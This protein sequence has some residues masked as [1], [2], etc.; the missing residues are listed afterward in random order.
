M[1][2]IILYHANH[3]K[4]PQKWID[5]CLM[6]IRGQVIEEFDV[7]E[8][9]Y[10]PTPTQLYEGSKF[11]T[12]A[13]KEKDKTH[14][15]HS[16]AHNWLCYKAVELGYDYV[17]NTNID[18]FY[19]Y[20][21]LYRQIPFLLQGYDVVSSNMTQIDQ[22]NRV[23]MK[24][25]RIMS[26]IAFSEMSIVEH[27]SKG[28]NIIAHPACAYSANFIRKSGM[29]KPEEVPKDDFELWKRSIDKFTFKIAPYTLLYYRIWGGN[30][31]AKK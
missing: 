26:D 23:I 24:G 22:D 4:Y 19:H 3:T 7:L 30:V 6:S 31:S 17:F 21:R 27:F 1:N 20:E 16:Y 13:F 12:Q 10:G 2:A 9:D 18:D 8:L 11:F 14:R 5:D 28:H 25:T 15:G 29:L